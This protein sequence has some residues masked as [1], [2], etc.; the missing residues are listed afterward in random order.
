MVFVI[1]KDKKPLT[2]CHFAVARKLLKQ[3]KAVVHKQFPFTIRLKELKEA[4]PKGLIIKL[5]PGAKQTG[6]ALHKPNG[7]VV[8]LATIEHR[9]NKIKQNLEARRSFRR[10]RRNRKTRYRAPRF[11]NR[12]QLEG[13]LPPSIQSIVDNVKNF[14]IKLKKLCYIETI[15]IETVRFDTQ[16]MLNPLI[17]GLDYQQGTLL[18]YEI[19][20]YL[21]YTY[22]HTCQ[23]CKGLTNDHQLEIEH[24]HPKSRGGSNSIRNLTLACRTC[25]Q[26][27]GNN[28]LDEWLQSL[29][30]SKLDKERV[31][32][33][34]S[35]LKTNKPVNLKDTAKVNSSRNA[36]LREMYKLTSDVVVSTGGVTKHNRVKAN[37]PKTHYYDALCVKETPKIKIHKGLKEL[38][39]KSIGRGTRSRTLL[40]KYGFPRAYLPRQKQFFGYQSG[41]MVK[42]N[43]PKGKYIGQYVSNVSCRSTGIFAIYSKKHGKQIDVNHKY[44]KLTQ[45]GDG[46]RYELKTLA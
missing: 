26:E 24:K 31:K 27:K 37:L 44:L 23:Y 33:I 18:G 11:L 20:E 8:L 39:I 16:L 13:W 42:A 5:D 22:G 9:A 19:R 3:G 1:N 21:L 38:Y 40:N 10:T 14:I 25:N 43:I 15:Y 6:V 34:N 35:I 36:V 28:T 30:K 4:N 29:S 46:Y 45:K 32:N 7:E 17:E 12:K 41:D 2:P